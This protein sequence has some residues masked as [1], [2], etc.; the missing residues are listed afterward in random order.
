M[1]FNGGLCWT[2]MQWA[3]APTAGPAPE[4]QKW[5]LWVGDW[6]LTGTAKQTATA[7][8]YKMDWRMQGRWI[9]GGHF[10][11]LRGTLSGTLSG[12]SKSNGGEST[13]LE[14]LSY[15]P[16]RRIHA[17]SGFDSDGDTWVATATF[18]PGTSIEMGTF[19]EPD[20]KTVTF[21]NT[22]NVSAD[23]MSI[24]GKIEKEQ[25]GVRWTA[26]TLKGTKAKPPSGK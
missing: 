7:P 23:G 5:D 9:L 13:S 20:G 6:T 11:E 10:V 1:S 22:W 26:F 18:T 24:S 8:E 17:F 3:Q 16:V 2:P 19:T 25:D 12:T 14:I 21:R 4:L 15:D